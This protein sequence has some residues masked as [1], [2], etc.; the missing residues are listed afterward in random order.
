MKLSE[1]ENISRESLLRRTIHPNEKTW[2]RLEK[3]LIANKR[4]KRFHFV[5]RVAAASIVLLVL[6]SLFFKNEPISNTNQRM[7]EISEPVL[8]PKT[9]KENT[10]T[11]PDAK[12]ALT[13]E[14]GNKTNTHL[15]SKKSTPVV[16]S[17]TVK[18]NEDI[19]KPFPIPENKNIVDQKVDEVVS[20]I[21][22]FQ[23]DKANFS[24]TEINALLAEALKEIKS[25]QL[26]TKA[27]KSVNADILLSE[28]E[29][30]INN[31]SFKEKVLLAL[32]ESYQTVK[33]AVAQSNN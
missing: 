19:E 18:V 15:S 5:S 28:V 11:E 31:S 10:L 13:T 29:E 25:Q 24:D 9:Q 32:R 14:D 20:K 16:V 26:L 21:L 8:T 2:D 17:E 12:T 27:G 23:K 6:I 4:K 30:D 3:Q 22:D 1:F 7:V 33:T